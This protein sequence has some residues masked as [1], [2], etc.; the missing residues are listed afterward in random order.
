MNVR[1][2][3]EKKSEKK[4]AE[5]SGWQ[6]MIRASEAHI[7]GMQEVLKILP[8]DHEEATAELRAGSDMDKVRNIL[9]QAGKPMHVDEIRGKITDRQWTTGEANGL[10]GSLNTY[11][12]KG[13]VFTKTAPKTFGL[14]EFNMPK[15]VSVLKEANG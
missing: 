4:R 7:E 15:N 9:R 1:T 3:I 5:I 12:K 8:L 10:A 14:I 2:E 11:A 13:R 6:A